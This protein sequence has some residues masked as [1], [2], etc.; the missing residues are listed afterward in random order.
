ME[1]AG[2][3]KNVLALGAGIIEGVGYGINSITALIVRGVAEIERF[4]AYFGAD[5]K[6][7]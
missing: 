3:L 6:T 7:F 5:S 1:I 2:A 4:A